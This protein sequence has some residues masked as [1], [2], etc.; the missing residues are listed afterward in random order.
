MK[1]KGVPAGERI[2]RGARRRISKPSGGVPQWPKAAVSHD[3]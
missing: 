2:H 1:V 3:G